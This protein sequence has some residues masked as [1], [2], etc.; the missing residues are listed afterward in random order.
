MEAGYIL[1]FLLDNLLNACEV[2]QISLSLRP[3]S[4]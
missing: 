1:T 3:Y 4:A 2:L